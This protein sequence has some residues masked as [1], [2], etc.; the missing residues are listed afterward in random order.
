MRVRY[1]GMMNKSIL[2]RW[3]VPVLFSLG[4]VSCMTSYDQYGRPMQTVDP[5]VAVAG[6]AAAG[7]VAYSIANNRNDKHRR[8]HH[9]YRKPAYGHYGHGHY[10]PGHYRRY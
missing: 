8:Y 7:L 9:G 6:A 10:R 3:A 1:T 5:A 2:L 4:S